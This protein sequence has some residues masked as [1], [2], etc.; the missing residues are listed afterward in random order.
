LLFGFWVLL[1]GTGAWLELLAGAC[2]SAVAATA[3][4][5]ARRKGDPRARVG[6]RELARAGGVPW[7]SLVELRVVLGSLRGGRP[8]GAFR[9][10]AVAARGRGARPTGRRALATV[11]GTVPPNTIVVDV[12]PKTGAALV[13]DLDPRRARTELP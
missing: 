13:H 10:I 11:A 4:S 2:A 7:D 12:D 6:L 9:S 5:V 3:H 1:V 8:H